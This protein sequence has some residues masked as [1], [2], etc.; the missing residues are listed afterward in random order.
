MVYKNFS[1]NLHIVVSL[2]FLAASFVLLLLNPL[3]L[4]VLVVGQ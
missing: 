3:L 2:F 1:C 4:P